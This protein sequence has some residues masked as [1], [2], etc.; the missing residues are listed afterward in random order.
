MSKIVLFLLELLLLQEKT[1]ARKAQV[2]LMW[3]TSQDSKLPKREPSLLIGFLRLATSRLKSAILSQSSSTSAP[4][5]SELSQETL[6]N[7]SNAKLTFASCFWLPC[8]GNSMRGGT[9][10]SNSG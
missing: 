7:P 1:S 8:L 6:A 10:T 4:V 3:L 5:G 9:E 2:E